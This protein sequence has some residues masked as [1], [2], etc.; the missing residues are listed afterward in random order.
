MPAPPGEC[1]RIVGGG[2]AGAAAALA[3]IQAGSTATVYEKSPVPR[4]RVCGEFLSPET[5]PVL[6]QLGLAGSLESSG[7]ARVTRMHL[8]FASASKTCLLPDPGYG[9]SRYALDRLL[10][11]VCRRRGADVLRAR[12]P[13][14]AGAGWIDAAGRQSTAPKG[15]RLFGF[16]AH[17]RGPAHDAVELYFFRGCYVGLN[18]VEDGFTNVCGLGPERI[19]RERGFQLDELL[20]GFQPLRERLAPLQRT[21]NWMHVGPLVF[22]N[23]FHEPGLSCYPAGD[24]LSFVDPFTGSGIASALISGRLA[25][26]A[27]ARRNEPAVYMKQATE[28]LG[29]PFTVAGALRKALCWSWAGPVAALIPGSYLFRL[30]RPAA[31]F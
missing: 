2:P 8:Q 16:K 24:A 17:Y 29:R 11:D 13:K 9:L 30:T 28:A 15:D 4:H 31:P 22:R 14:P 10:L 12:A 19:L 25:G 26:R 23:R 27:A 7:S 21:M 6:D 5:L 3:A 20:E 18:C 1:V